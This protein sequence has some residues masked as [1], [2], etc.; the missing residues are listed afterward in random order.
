MKNLWRNY[1][2]GIILFGL[3]FFSWVGQGIVQLAEVKQDAIAHHQEFEW[4]EYWT[5][6]GEATLEN[7]QSEFLQL[8]TFVVLTKYFVYKGSDQSK[9]PEELD[10]DK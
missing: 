2:L 4:S 9:N 1:A 3:F 8:F 6:F 5:R 10:D 7:W